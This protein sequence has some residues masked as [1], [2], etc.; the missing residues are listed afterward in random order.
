MI[1]WVY[2]L[3]TRGA[4]RLAPY[5]VPFVSPKLKAWLDLRGTALSSAFP[6][7]PLEGAVWIHFAS[8]EIEYVRPLVARLR[9]DGRSFFLT[10]SSPTMAAAAAQLSPHAFPIPWDLP[11]LWEDFLNR[12]RPSALWIARTDLWPEMLRAAKSA[13]IPR[14]LFAATQSAPISRHSWKWHCLSLV[15][16]IL[17]VSE[18]DAESLRASGVSVPIQAAGDPRYTQVVKRLQSPKRVRED[19]RPRGH[20]PVFILGSSWDQDEDWVLRGLAP[21]VVSRQLDLII[22]PHE[23]SPSHLCHLEE[24]IRSHGLEFTRYSVATG[25]V[26]GVMIV[27]Q[28]G[29]LAELYTWAD[30]AFVGGSVGRQVH[31]VM[32][33]L[34]AGCLTIVGPRHLK[35]REALE[36]KELAPPWVRPVTGADALRAHTEMLLTQA[37]S[38]SVWKKELR[39]QIHQRAEAAG[40]VYRQLIN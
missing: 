11:E 26:P 14:L 5:L 17:T 2:L 38:W 32:E 25:P 29:I 31:S 36:F 21:L 22:V 35:N 39:D 13:H 33:A 34:A 3:C 15:S 1:R 18:S 12:T 7:P 40:G 19:V 8:G 23:P 9:E 20:R 16:K 10:F 24:K 4:R 37:G 27:D 30:M 6:P 28:V